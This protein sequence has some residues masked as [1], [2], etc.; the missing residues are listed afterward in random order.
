[1]KETHYVSVHYPNSDKPYC[2]ATD[3]ADLQP[4]DPVVVLTQNGTQLA[5]VCSA[6]RPLT[7]YS[8]DLELKPIER[9]ASKSDLD[10]YQFNLEAAKKA[11]EAT[12]EEIKKLDLPMD[13][14]GGEYNLEGNHVLITYTTPEKR[15]DFRVLLT[16]IAPRI[17]GRVELRQIA[18]RDKAKMIGGLGPC[19]L[20]LCCSTFLNQFEGISISRVKNQMLTINIPKLSG[21]CGKL[22][23]C[24]AYEDDT[25]TQEKKD[26]PRLGT[27]VKFDE[28]EYKVDSYNVIS[29]TVRLCTQDRQNS[30]TYPLEDVLAMIN[31]TY[32]KKEEK[33]EEEFA[34]PDYGVVSGR[35]KDVSYGGMGNRGKIE[36]NGKPEQRQNGQGKAGR[37]N[38][39][40]QQKGNQPNNGNAQKGKDGQSGPNGSQNQKR[41]NRHRHYHRPN[42]PK[43]EAK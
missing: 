15:V 4:S 36:Q 38:R 25:Y 26:F 39:G 7:E 34:L 1:M 19:G 5:F 14:I 11:V 28:G 41:H 43:Q 16:K 37:N 30:K 21:Q 22:M 23:C 17:A 12:K 40:G 10:N 33:K 20:P 13:V 18:P 6:P 35:F 8:S 29:R 27:I 9:K 32:R 3:I 2:F 24:L 31:G 42:K